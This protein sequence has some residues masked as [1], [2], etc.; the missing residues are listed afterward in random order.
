MR[1]DRRC[2]LLLRR[3]GMVRIVFGEGVETSVAGMVLVVWRALS[4]IL[5][6]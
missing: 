6:A 2:A 5:L 1:L 4:W 3:Y